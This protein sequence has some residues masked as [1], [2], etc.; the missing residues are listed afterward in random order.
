MM[1]SVTSMVSN[2][3]KLGLLAL[4][5]SLTSLDA[6]ALTIGEDGRTQVRTPATIDASTVAILNPAGS[7]GCTGI[8]VGL[9]FVATSAA[10]V[11]DFE[12]GSPR[13]GLTVAPQYH[14]S[15]G[16]QPVEPFEMYRIFIP[17]ALI[18]DYGFNGW[19]Q[20]ATEWNIAIVQVVE[21]SPEARF[22]DWAPFVDI[23]FS[24]TSEL[25]GQ[26]VTMTDYEEQ[27][28]FTQTCNITASNGVSFEPPL[29]ECDTGE[30]SYGA[31]LVLNGRVVGVHSVENPRRGRNLYAAFSPSWRDDLQ[32]IILQ[33]EF[34]DLEQFDVF[35]VWEP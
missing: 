3:V 25:A 9:S 12:T 15:L 31:G 26:S 7:V 27:D 35:E 29:H 17:A 28:Q 23:G 20:F 33:Y 32:K 34:D 18:Q 4:G 19:T 6:N 22:E 1:N 30:R 5:V 14:G 21:L 13:E 11:Y 16:L 8:S 10:C 2:S 24:T